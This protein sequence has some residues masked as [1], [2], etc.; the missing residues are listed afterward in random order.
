MD[1]NLLLSTE[2]TYK[3]QNSWQHGFQTNCEAFAYYYPYNQTVPAKCVSSPDEGAIES[4]VQSV[5]NI[6]LP[7]SSI[8]TSLNQLFSI[9]GQ[10]WWDFEGTNW[11][12][13]GEK[14]K[15]QILENDRNVQ[16]NHFEWA[17]W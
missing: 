12:F 14:S 10:H 6:T 13:Y 2:C 8:W 16:R 1:S 5:F 7:V 11:V 15:S 3:L 9:D 4:A 17:M